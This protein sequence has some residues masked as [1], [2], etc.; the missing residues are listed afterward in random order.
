MAKIL[1]AKIWRK[2]SRQE[3]LNL[4]KEDPVFP[5]SSALQ[6]PSWS[7]PSRFPPSRF[8]LCRFPPCR[9]T[10]CRFPPSRFPPSRFTPVPVSPRAGCCF[11]GFRLAGFRLGDFRFAAAFCSACIDDHNAS[12]SLLLASASL[13]LPS[14]YWFLY[15]YSTCISEFR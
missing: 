4:Q 9:F 2:G 12:S 13:Q 8:P 5:L 14:C 15:F 6:P 1:T 3:R 11:A 10:T 7:S